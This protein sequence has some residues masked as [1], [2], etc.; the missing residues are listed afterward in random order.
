[1]NWFESLVIP[2]SLTTVVIC[3]LSILCMLFSITIVACILATQKRAYKNVAHVTWISAF[4]MMIAGSISTCFFTLVSL[5]LDEH[6]AILDYTEKNKEASGVPSIY[7]NKI[8][9]LMNTCLFGQEK[10]AA[11]ELDLIE[12]TKAVNELNCSS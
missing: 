8:A 10:N 12:E 2:V 11:I 6:C 4:I 1:M 7:P 9:P 5:L 3:S